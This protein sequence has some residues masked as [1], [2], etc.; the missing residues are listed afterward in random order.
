LL[1]NSKLFKLT[2]KQKTPELYLANEVSHDSLLVFSSG[3]KFLASRTNVFPDIREE[4]N[5]KVTFY[6]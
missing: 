2:H 1:N 3:D 4:R 6:L 5:G